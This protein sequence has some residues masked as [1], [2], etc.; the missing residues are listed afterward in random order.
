MSPPAAHS[1]NTTAEPKYPSTQ[2]NSEPP[3]KIIIAI[4]VSLHIAPT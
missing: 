4:N 2:E 3:Q 1:K